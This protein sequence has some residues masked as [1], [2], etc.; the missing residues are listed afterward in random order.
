MHNRTKQATG[1]GALGGRAISA[2]AFTLVEMLVVIM[3]IGILVGIMMPTLG[4]VRVS[5]LVQRSKTTINQVE[6]AI[7]MYHSDHEEYPAGADVLVTAVATRWAVARGVTYGP[8][9][10]VDGLARRKAQDGRDR[11]RHRLGHVP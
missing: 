3:I 10:G 2:R 9:N 4:R 6:G 8:Y 7:K 5:I 11:R 1:A